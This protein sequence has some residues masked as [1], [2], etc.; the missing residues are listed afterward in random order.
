MD[1]TCAVDECPRR[2]G[3]GGYCWTHYNQLRKRGGIFPITKAPAGE[4]LEQRLARF[5]VASDEQECWT[6]TG[7]ASQRGP[8]G[9]LK[10]KGKL[11]RAHREVYRLLV[12]E[13]PDGLTLDHL[14]RNTL[15][16]NP[17]HLE[18]VTRRANSERQA[19]ALYRSECLRGHPYTPEN[20]YVNRRGCRSCKTC[21]AAAIIKHRANKVAP[22]YCS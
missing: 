8:Y 18:P 14:C 13:I 22:G 16:V 10:V 20:T 12:G 17:Q 7:P 15:C 19:L 3:T 5:F 11:H 1:R 4:S 6:W 2:H 9:V 21:R